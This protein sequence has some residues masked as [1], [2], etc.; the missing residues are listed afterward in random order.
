KIKHKT[1][2]NL[3]I[4]SQEEIAA[5]KLALK[6]KGNLT[7]L[8]SIKDVKTILGKSIGAV[9]TIKSIADKTQVSKALGNTSQSRLSTV[10]TPPTFVGFGTLS[11][12]LHTGVM[13]ISVKRRT[14]FDPN[15]VPLF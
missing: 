1:I 8:S 11:K 12:G 14:Y 4:C 6:H 7:A 15:F 9:W 5:I 3:S 13:K 10:S 2:L